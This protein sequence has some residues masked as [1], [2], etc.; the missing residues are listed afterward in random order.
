MGKIIEFFLKKLED[1]SIISLRKARALTI[2][3]L[4]VLVLMVFFITNLLVTKGISGAVVAIIVAGIV[5]LNLFIIWRGKIKFA[6][7][8]ISFSLIM[9]EIFSIFANVSGAQPFN[10]FADEF[11]IMLAFILLT[12]LFATRLLL[13]INTFIVL[14]T[15]VSAH[16]YNLSSYH[17]S[18]VGLSKSSI[19]I[20][21]VIVIVVFL[22]SYFFRSNMEVALE[23]T[24]KEAKENR[25]MT[26]KLISVIP[27][28]KETS[29]NLNMLAQQIE[30]FSKELADKASELG[31]STEQ[32]ST[33][34]EEISNTSASNLSNAEQTFEKSKQTEQVVSK[35]NSAMTRIAD[36]VEQVVEKISVIN[37]I[38]SK[39]NL[40][41]INAAI[42]AARAGESGRGFSIVAQEVKKLSSVSAH[43]AGEII[44]LVKITSKVSNKAKEELNETISKVKET[45]EFISILR[46]SAKEQA[47]G[48]NEINTGMQEVSKGSQL[49][50][51]ISDNLLES[52]KY[53]NDSSLKLRNL[54]KNIQV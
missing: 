36:I 42:E 40:L 48:F 20:Y 47:I 25:K 11:Y 50:I 38:A 23:M 53:M 28:V 30:I 9:L 16:I 31:A 51:S 35:A 46:E 17:E 1:K 52:V 10:F 6:G 45:S 8:F 34:V 3:H 5:L 21:V 29:S 43:A 14:A 18:V 13:I 2:I 44:D 37:E 27:P 39:T 22:L 54:L 32:I 26:E 7:N 33:A 49:N 4:S 41:A 24:E 12:A 19:V 15:A